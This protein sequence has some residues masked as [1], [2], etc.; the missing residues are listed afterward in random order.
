M[1]TVMREEKWA[2]VGKSETLPSNETKERVCKD[3][4][5]TEKWDKIM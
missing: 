2:A 4:L 3:F 1:E 5:D